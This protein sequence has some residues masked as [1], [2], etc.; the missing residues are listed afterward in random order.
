MRANSF[1][2]KALCLCFGALAVVLWVLHVVAVRHD[3]A[4]DCRVCS[5]ALMPEL[6]ADCGGVLGKPEEFFVPG[7]ALF[8]AA[9]PARKPS[10][11]R[12]RSPPLL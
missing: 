3:A 9:V 10:L 8:V 7:P 6:N 11:C 1:T 5:V 12:G 4:D 2:K